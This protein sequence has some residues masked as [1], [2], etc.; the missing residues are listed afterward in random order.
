MIKKL[1]QAALMAACIAQPALAQPALAQEVQNSN[2]YL[3]GGE[4]SLDG[5]ELNDA[6]VAART[7]TAE[8]F[9]SQGDI[10]MAALNINLAGNIGENLMAAGNNISLNNINIQEDLL[11]AGRNLLIDQ[12]SMI[13]GAVK[14]AGQSLEFHGKVSGTADLAAQE[15]ILSGDFKG[16][17]LVRTTTLIIQDDTK[18]HGTLLLKGEPRLVVSQRA[19]ITGGITREESELGNRFKDWERRLSWL[20]SSFLA[21]PLLLGLGLA[22]FSPERLPASSHLIKRQSWFMMVIGLGIILFF[23]IVGALMMVTVIGIPIGVYLLA[24]WPMVI[25]FGATIGAYFVGDILFQR[26]KPNLGGQWYLRMLRM[27]TGGVILF[28]IGFVPYVGL[29]PIVA[30]TIL[31]AGS[32]AYIRWRQGSVYYFN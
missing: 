1:W 32:V 6:Y 11:L 19:D 14:I 17:V 18:I 27:I 7:I 25:L 3:F 4:L 24:T 16:D 30:A 21:L 5:M 10:I 20:T 2:A 26:L 29:L 9:S 23:P 12:D 28:A 22:V 13:K 15:I 31:G 8:S